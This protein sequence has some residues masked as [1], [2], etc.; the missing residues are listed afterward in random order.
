MDLNWFQS[1]LYGFLSGLMDIL[2]VSA[3]AHNVLLMKF[4]G[5]KGETP[6]LELLIHLGIFA[7]LY[8]SVQTQLV[9]LSR[10]KAL[11]RIPKRKRKRPLDTR[12][13]MDLSLLK[14]M[15]VPGILGL[16]LYQYALK[17]NG[18]LVLMAGFLFLNG[19][20]LYVPQFL[21]SGNRDSRTLSRVEGLLMGLG[22]AA[23]ILPGVSAVGVATSIGSVCG[24]ERSYSLTM[25]L[26]MNLF[27]TVGFIIYDGMAIVGAGLGVLSFGIL[28]RYLLTA[29]CAF[30][31]TLL[32]I[33]TM[34]H[35]AANQGYGLFGLYC[36]G[37]ALFT[38]ILNLMA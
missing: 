13:L 3:R 18:N 35:L 29:L 31:G 6:F 17:L 14:T 30:G 23:S 22:G 20:I 36:F 12:S 37:L 2:P 16:F 7:A 8:Y 10:A 34:R 1:I 26:M 27:L 9:R 28:I 25:A 5:I 11:A 32:G 24:V 19:F 15:L 4:F 21:P 38:F 33:K